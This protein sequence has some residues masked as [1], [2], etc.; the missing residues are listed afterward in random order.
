MGNSAGRSERSG[1]S[2]EG[3]NPGRKQLQN[4]VTLWAG[5][6]VSEGC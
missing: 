5:R 6:M 2:G 3:G 1:C 4:E